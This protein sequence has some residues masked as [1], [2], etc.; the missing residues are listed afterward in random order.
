MR[1][2]DV[3]DLSPVRLADYILVL[4]RRKWVVLIAVLAMSLGA[5]IYSVRQ[6]PRYQASADVLLNQGDIARAITNVSGRNPDPTRLAATQAEIARSPLLA[7]QV[8]TAADVG[9]TSAELLANSTVSP[10]GNADVLSFSVVDESPEVAA[11][12]AT[13][14]ASQYASFLR[15]MDT[16]PVRDALRNL[17]AK[18]DLLLHVS[19]LYIQLVETQRKLELAETLATA[20]GTLL[21]P[22]YGASKIAPNPKRAVTLGALAGIVLGLAL[23]FFFEALDNRVRSEHEAEKW[24]RIPLLGRVP[25]PIRPQQEGELV[26]VTDPESRTA[27]AFRQLRINLEFANIEAG[28]RTIIVTS[29]VEREGKTTTAANLAVALAR[30]GQRVVLVDLDLRQPSLHRFFGA[31]SWPGVTDVIVGAVKLDEAL[32]RVPIGAIIRDLN[33]LE[34]DG[35]PPSPLS[36]SETLA[37]PSEDFGTLRGAIELLPLGSIPPDPGEFVANLALGQVLA[38]VRERADTVLIDTPPMLSVG[39]VMTLSAHAD[40]LLPVVRLHQTPRAALVALSRE[41]KTSS[42]TTLGFI[43]TDSAFEAGL[44]VTYE[45]VYDRNVRPN[46]ARDATQSHQRG[47]V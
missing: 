28:A 13:T 31:R 40:A 34:S 39:D 38:T 46:T 20:N 43:A 6:P 21:R 36:P 22:A 47:A 29:A 42:A 4:R 24:L 1:D 7:R 41:L 27:E 3:A 10:W 23:A 14:Y 35:S 16:K 19:P 37:G 18:I 44:A 25:P 9:R 45:A 5:C 33:G 30:A 32:K 12:L 11:R 26:M 15:E 2:L 17:E 8:V